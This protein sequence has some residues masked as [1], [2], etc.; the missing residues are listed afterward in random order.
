MATTKAKSKAATATSA[1]A[2]AARKNGTA[3]AGSRPGAGKVTPI[4][5]ADMPL[6]EGYVPRLDLPKGYRPSADEEYMSP[7]QLEYFRRKLL[8]WRHELIEE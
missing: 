2:P 7:R 8:V 5:V 6:P 1:A 4:S 3:Q